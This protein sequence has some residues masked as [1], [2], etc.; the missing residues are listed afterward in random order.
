M[1]YVVV[2]ASASAHNPPRRKNQQ[3]D[4]RP[5]W[6]KDKT[7]ENGALIRA[8]LVE[9]FVQ[10]VE[11]NGDALAQGD[12]ADQILNGARRHLKRVPRARLPKNPSDFVGGDDA[13]AASIKRDQPNK[14]GYR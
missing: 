1:I 12:V 5:R 13:G 2:A 10:A 14:H 8:L 11:V 9:L 6:T 4:G 3:H 7:G